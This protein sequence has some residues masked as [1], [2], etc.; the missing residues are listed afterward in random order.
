MKGVI[1]AAGQGSRLGALNSYTSKPALPLLGQTIL[2]RVYGSFVG[3]VD[4]IVIVINPADAH[5]RKMLESFEPTSTHFEIIEQPE[6]VGSA[7]AL[8]KAWPSLDGACIV[9][10]CDNLV[11]RKY[12]IEFMRYFLE[13]GQDALLALGNIER[14]TRTPSSVV[15][16]DETGNVTKIIEKPGPKQV[17]SDM[18]ALPLYAFGATFLED[19]SRLELSIRNEYEL[20]QAIQNLINRGGVVRGKLI[21]QR[22][23][24]NNPEE[25]LEA[26]RLLLIKGVTGVDQEASIAGS[27]EVCP[28]VY[29]E[30]SAVIQSGATVGPYAYLMAGSTVADGATVRDAIVFGEASVGANQY[31]REQIILRNEIINLQISRDSHDPAHRL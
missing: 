15:E 28:P 9:T 3:L 2:E 11:E 1:L 24:V 17:I 20:P 26:V 21:P 4:S 31:V 8:R 16:I 6:P 10:S 27:A 13:R 23:T 7:D 25:Y 22:I 19:L 18:M 29:I 5:T 12:L 30:H 14:A